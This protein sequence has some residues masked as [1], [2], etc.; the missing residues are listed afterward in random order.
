MT[1]DAMAT[2]IDWLDAYRAGDITAILGMYAD[3][4]VVECGC[5]GVTVTGKEALRAYWE[6]RLRD[7]PASDLDDIQ[8]SNGV[9]NISYLSHD[10]IVGAALEFDAHGMIARLQCGPSN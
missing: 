10:R 5:N 1:F 6:K 9:A 8:W 3:D 4:A 7:H 2:A